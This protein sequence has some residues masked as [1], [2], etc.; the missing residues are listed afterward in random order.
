MQGD[1]PWKS[2]NFSVGTLLV[3]L[4]CCVWGL[5]SGIDAG[6][7][8]TNR[9][10]GPRLLPLTLAGILGLV[11]CGFVVSVFLGKGVVVTGA[12]R[13]NYS[14]GPVLKLIGLLVVYLL[15]MPWIGFVLG[16]SLFMLTLLRLWGERW[17]SAGLA[18]FILVFGV[19][20]IFTFIFKAPLPVS[21]LGIPF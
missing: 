17:S 21:E 20:V 9:D 10:P 13:G 11:G 1:R 16:S 6:G 2:Q 15:V 7:F 14:I 8:D 12:D 18:T 19:K 3:I 5:S 4:A